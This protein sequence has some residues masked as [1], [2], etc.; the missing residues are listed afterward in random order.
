M[1]H[2]NLQQV[3]ML[4]NTLSHPNIT[5]FVHADKKMDLNQADLDIPGVILLPEEKR[6]SL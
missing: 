1:I 4:I 3:K 6:R 2:N 5:I